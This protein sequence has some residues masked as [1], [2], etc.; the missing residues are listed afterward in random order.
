MNLTCSWTNAD[1]DVAYLIFLTTTT[2]YTIVAMRSYPSESN[3]V[4]T[5]WLDDGATVVFQFLYTTISDSGVYECA[6]SSGISSNTV[7]VSVGTG[8]SSDA[9]TA[10]S[11]C[12]LAEGESGVSEF[13]VA[14][15]VGALCGFFCILVG[16]T[17]LIIRT[18]HRERFERLF[19]FMHRCDPPLQP[20]NAEAGCR[21]DD[22]PSY[23]VAVK[24][25]STQN[26]YSPPSYVDVVSGQLDTSTSSQT[27]N[28]SDSSVDN[29][30]FA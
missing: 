11:P 5:N 28:S 26:L 27:I 19:K 15:L 29:H 22:L 7:V 9:S 24:T 6:I 3:R 25:V 2:T 17:L 1:E 13:N 4:D 8:N 14:V 18:K 21:N 10:G 20:V 16:I 30:G 12:Y 23:E